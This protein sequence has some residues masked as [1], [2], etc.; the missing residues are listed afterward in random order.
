[1]RHHNSSYYPRPYGSSTVSRAEIRRRKKQQRIKTAVVSVSCIFIA[2]ASAAGV[3]LNAGSGLPF[4]LSLGGERPSQILH[5]MDYP[6]HSAEKPVLHIYTAPIGPE[7]PV[8]EAATPAAKYDFSLPVPESV[9]VDDTYFDDAVFIGDSRAEGFMLYS[10]LSN[11][12]SYAYK[13]LMVDTVFTNPV[14]AMG[15]KKVPVMTALKS[16]DFSKVYIMLG[17]N[18]TGWAYSNLFVEKYGKIIDEIKEINPAALIY[19]QSILPVTQTVS[20]THSYVKKSRIDEYNTLLQQMCAERE[21]FYVNV[22]QCM[23]DSEGYLPEAA[24]VD[25]IHLK[26]EYC[27][28]WLTYLQNHTYTDTSSTI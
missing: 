15:G 10:G 7:I 27:L 3:C 19:V 4:A 16:T 21:I 8:S 1:M 5:Q 24:A 28:K 25:G 18:E 6:P 22:A 20:S 13:G 9:T 14:I 12:T 17:V 11:A 23:T 26:K 2:A